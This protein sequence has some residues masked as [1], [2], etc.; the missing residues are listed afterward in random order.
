MKLYTI[1]AGGK[2]Y[3]VEPSLHEGF[4]SVSRDDLSVLIA[5]DLEGHWV[6]TLPDSEAINFPV[7]EIGKEIEKVQK[8]ERK[9]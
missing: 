5:K 2:E 9:I 8:S 1:V 7:K 4:Y 6:L 3:I